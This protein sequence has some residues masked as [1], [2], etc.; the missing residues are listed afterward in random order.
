MLHDPS[1]RYWV[2]C[3]G[4]CPERIA[5]PIRIHPEKSP[6]REYLPT[7]ERGIRILCLH[8]GTLFWYHEADYRQFRGDT[9]DP[10]QLT[11]SF[12]AS[13]PQCGHA[14]CAARFL[15]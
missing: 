6:I 7:D 15:I 3:Q 11:N 4:D 9:T 5:L 8:C 2:E 14:G 10:N 1:S 13:T 12:W